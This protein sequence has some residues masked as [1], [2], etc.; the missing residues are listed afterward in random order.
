M[1]KCVIVGVTSSIAAYKSVQL[2]SDLIKNDIDVEVVMSKNA[3][4]FITPLTF[5]SLTKHKTYVDTFERNTDFQVE[6]IALADKADAFIVAPASANIIAKA[7]NGIADD[8]LS[9]TLLACNCPKILAPAM[10]T[11]MYNN[12]ITQ[13]NLAKLKGYGFKIVEPLSGRLACGDT[14]IGKLASIDMLI[15][16]LNDALSPKTLTG[17]KVLISA[18]ATLESL[19]PVRYI[20]NHSS[21]KQ[22]YAL[23]KAARNMGASVTL[24]SG[25]TNLDVISGINTIHVTSAAQMAE[26][27]IGLSPQQDVIIMAAAVADFT[28]DSV[29]QKIKKNNQPLTIQ[30]KPTTDILATL[31]ATRRDDQ[32]IIGFAMESENL[33]ANARQKLVSKKC[34]MIVANSIALAG[35]GFGV[36]TNIATLI[37]PKRE[38][39]LAKMSKDDLAVKIMEWVAKSC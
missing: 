38:I 17:L 19:D 28:V 7:A 39:E 2:V 5:S 29:P 16:A 3:T 20:T 12:P 6:H 34:D 33:L 21:G 22:G 35:S 23:A 9:T 11:K 37:T 13:D 31:G 15:D 24:V 4:N 18:G 1:K 36:D 10:N 27:I 25:R 8:M 30:L 26:T 14:G 32:I